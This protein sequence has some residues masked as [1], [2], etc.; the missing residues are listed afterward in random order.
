MLSKHWEPIK[1]LP[2]II[3]LLITCDPITLIPTSETE[4][5]PKLSN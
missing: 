5:T 1:I 4:E 2:M 3:K